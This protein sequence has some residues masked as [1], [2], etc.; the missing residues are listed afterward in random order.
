MKIRRLPEDFQVEELTS[1]APAAEERGG[2]HALYL[3]TKRSLGTPEAVDI[4]LRRWKLLR[5]K[6]SYGGL[7]DRHAITRQHLTIFHGPRRG[8]RQDNLELVYLGQTA[9]PFHAKDIVGNRFEIV[10]R[11]LATD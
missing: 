3:L 9:E 1:V 8:M 11:D 2:P 4:V 6:V 5:E 10:V 7:K